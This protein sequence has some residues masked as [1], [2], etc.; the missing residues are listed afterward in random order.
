[1][2]A[3]TGWEF[4]R[5]KNEKDDYTVFYFETEGGATLSYR[6]D[7]IRHLVEDADKVGNSSGL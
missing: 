1:M 7:N 5:V 6:I 3:I 4:K 2:E